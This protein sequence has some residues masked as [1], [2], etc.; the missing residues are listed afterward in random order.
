MP[1]EH[2]RRSSGGGADCRVFLLS[3]E[4]DIPVPRRGGSGVG[5]GGGL[6]GLHPR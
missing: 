4:H 1:M 3:A 6:Q 2:R 5:G